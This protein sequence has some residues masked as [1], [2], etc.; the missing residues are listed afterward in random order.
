VTSLRASCRPTSGQTRSAVAA[1]QLG[2]DARAVAGAATGLFSA[3][4]RALSSPIAT[5]EEVLDFTASLRRILG[6]PPAPPSPLLR[7]RS[8]RSW[9]FGALECRLDDLK[10][11]ARA[12]RGSLND[13][14][15]AVLLG[16]LRRYHE[17]FGVEIEELPMTIP[18]SLRR[19]DDPMGG[20]RFTGALFA[21]PAG[22][23]DPAERIATIRGIVLSVRSEPA[24]DL[25]GLLSPLLNRAP[26]ALAALA[27]GRLGATAD[28]AASNV[29]GIPYA[30]YAAG[31]RVERLFPF[32]PLPGVAVMAALVSHAGTC[33][34]GINCDAAAVENPEL[35][36]TCLQE[37]LD[38]VLAIAEDG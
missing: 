30:V 23:A 24:L 27:F 36:M 20:N 15:L 25:L 17:R 18:V 10:A 4:S 22:V 2:R 3:V 13:A 31:A 7:G 1:E 6:G 32:G 33:C 35:L 28:L 12:G 21:G 16:G 29:P 8:G 5:A 34:L 38:E 19:E 11:A 14:Y 37:G 9:R 26:P